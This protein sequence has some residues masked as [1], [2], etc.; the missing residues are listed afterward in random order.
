MVNLITFGNFAFL[1]GL[2]AGGSDLRLYDGSDFKT[3][4]HIR[5][6]VPDIVSVVGSTGVYVLALF[7]SDMQLCV[8]LNSFCFI[9]FLYLN[10]DDTSIS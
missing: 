4:L 1:F 3:Y 8:L 7:N 10:G 5:E 6:L 9:S 2:H